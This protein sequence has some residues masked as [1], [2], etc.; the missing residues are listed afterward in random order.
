M[1]DIKTAA[2]ELEEVDLALS[3]V[4][5]GGQSYQIGSRKLTRADYSALVERRKELLAAVAA[6]SDTGL[7]DDTFVAVFQG[8]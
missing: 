5:L 2:Q 6:E 3:R 8:R 1:A 4:A 7:I